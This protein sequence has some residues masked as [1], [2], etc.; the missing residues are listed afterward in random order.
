MSNLVSTDW[1]AAHL[2][3]VRVVDANWYM[4]GDPRD[5][6]ADYRTA[7][8]PG[9]VYFD[10]DAVADHSTAA[11]TSTP[12]VVPERSRAGSAAGVIA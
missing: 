6:N 8:I 12:L 9:A 2:G 11:I 3:E 10:I 5:A 1:L 7:H 4:P